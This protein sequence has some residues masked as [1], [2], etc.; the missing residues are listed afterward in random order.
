MKQ[1][2]FCSNDVEYS[3]AQAA[4]YYTCTTCTSC[5]HIMKH[6]IFCNNDVEYSIAQAT[7]SYTC[8][9][10]TSCEN[11]LYFAPQKSSNSYSYQVLYT[12]GLSSGAYPMKHNRL[13]M[14]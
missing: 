9:T 12:V 14:N 5:E 7:M 6:T 10:C 1:T 13:K 4:M 2:I 8:T 11:I 3:I